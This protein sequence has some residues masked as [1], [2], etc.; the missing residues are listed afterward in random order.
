MARR[1]RL[2]DDMLGVLQYRVDKGGLEVYEAIEAME[3]V[4][5]HGGGA[6][7]ADLF[8]RFVMSKHHSMLQPETFSRV[9]ITSK[10]LIEW[11]FARAMLC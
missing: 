3:M 5:H 4:A 1:V 7:R 9:A 10:C 8:G 6:A 2:S 11:H